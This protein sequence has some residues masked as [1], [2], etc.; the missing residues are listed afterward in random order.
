MARGRLARSAGR[1][2][3]AGMRRALALVLLGVWPAVRVAAHVVPVPPS[4]CRFEP[5]TL[6]VSATGV[7][8]AAAAATDADTVLLKYDTG[9]SSI[10]VCPAAAP[11]FTAC[12]PVVPRGFTLGASTGTLAFPA[13]FGATLLASGDALVPSLPVQMTLDGAGATATFRLTTGLVDVAGTVREGVPLRDLESF[14]LVGTAAPDTLPGTLLGQTVVL[15][16][17]CQPRPI[18]DKD[19]FLL[20]ARVATLAGR[21]GAS[22]A[23][24]RAT[25]ELPTPATL[26][27][28]AAPAMLL[29]HVAGQ[30]VGA[31]VVTGGL[32]GKHAKKGKSDDGRSTLSVK[33]KG[34]KLLVTARLGAVTMTSQTPGVPVDVDLV[35]D[36]GGLLARGERLFH[37]SRN[38]RTLKPR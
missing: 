36:A 8:G 34:T 19:Q 18:P 21:I 2:Y 5:M 30:P 24:L 38:G 37:A 13:Q 32:A 7:G 3:G 10:V 16:L 20:P 6:E 25:V 1:W 27:F 9:T 22:T 33:Q 29:V 4:L 23:S 14:V 35:L 15:R 11:D 26:D 17:S 28:G 31:V 12:G